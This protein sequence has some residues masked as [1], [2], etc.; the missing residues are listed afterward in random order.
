MT[1]TTV[2]ETVSGVANGVANGHVTNGMAN[3]V[4]KA[5]PAPERMYVTYDGVHKSIINSVELLRLAGWDTP[6]YLIA[7]SGGGLIPARILRTALRTASSNG[8]CAAIK[9]IGLELYSD[10]LD[11]R[12]LER[13]VVRT[14]WL[15]QHSTQLV[16][17]RILIV[18]EVDDSRATLAYATREL[19]ADIAAEEGVLAAQGRPVPPTQLGVFV[20][21]NKQRPKAGALPEGVPQ[22]VAQ[23]LDSDP[24]ICYPWDAQDIQEHTRLAHLTG[25]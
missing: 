10:E 19:L 13:G 8:A 24:W 23:E 12:P 9:V 18:D 2:V 4:A 14:Q 17:K 1:V 3:G 15:E 5:A 22:F 21:H 20:L 16:G 7:I 11:G 25:R 6:D